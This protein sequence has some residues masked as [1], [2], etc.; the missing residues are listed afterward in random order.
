MEEGALDM[1]MQGK[2]LQFLALAMIDLIQKVHSPSFSSL[3]NNPSK[4]NIV[5]I[6]K[7][8]RKNSESYSITRLQQPIQTAQYCK[9]YRMKT[10]NHLK[11]ILTILWKFPLMR[12]VQAKIETQFSK[13][14][15]LDRLLY[16]LR[17]LLM[18]K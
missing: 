17:H 15:I 9:I 6:K 8:T 5:M 2:V 1:K 16:E 12:Q 10:S 3:E 13:L 14:T 18:K 7:E 11:Q 4:K